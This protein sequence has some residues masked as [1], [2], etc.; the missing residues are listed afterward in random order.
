MINRDLK[1]MQEQS[2]FR[3]ALQTYGEDW[4]RFNQNEKNSL[5]KHFLW[6]KKNLKIVYKFFFQT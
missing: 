2:F 6:F 4:I 1:K 5:I 3:G